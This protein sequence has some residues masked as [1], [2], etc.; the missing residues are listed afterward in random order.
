MTGLVTSTFGMEMWEQLLLSGLFCTPTLVGALMSMRGG[1]CAPYLSELGVYTPIA[2]SL[3]LAITVAV[4]D[5]EARALHAMY[6]SRIEEPLATSQPGDG[7]PIP[8]EGLPNLIGPPHACTDATVVLAAGWPE[9]GGRAAAD[10]RMWGV[11][12]EHADPEAPITPCRML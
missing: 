9:A 11:P 1:A 10:C 6:R 12:E 2:M 8:G 4:L 5:R 7:P 3:N